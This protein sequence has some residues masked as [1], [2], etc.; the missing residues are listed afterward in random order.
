[1]EITAIADNRRV[2]LESANRALNLPENRLFDSAEAILSQPRLAVVCSGWT[3]M[4]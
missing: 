1:M 3:T 4:L 2:R